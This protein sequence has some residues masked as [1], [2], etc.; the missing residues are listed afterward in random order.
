M[1]IQISALP[2]HSLLTNEHSH[3]LDWGYLNELLHRSKNSQNSREM[4]HGV[5]LLQ[6]LENSS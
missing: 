6:F 5:R 1:L 2:P 4:A 3:T